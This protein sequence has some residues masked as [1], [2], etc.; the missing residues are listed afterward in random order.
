M[1]KKY[2]VSYSSNTGYGWSEEC[3]SL[4]N[5]RS[6]IKEYKNNLYACITVWDNVKHKMLFDKRILEAKPTVDFLAI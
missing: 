3:N 6:L 4:K 2:T 1:N 5:V